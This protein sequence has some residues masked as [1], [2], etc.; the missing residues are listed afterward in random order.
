[1]KKWEDE[2]DPDRVLTPEE[3]SRRVDFKRR[4]H[5]KRII[6]KRWRD[7]RERQ[8]ASGPGDAA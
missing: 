3:R 5:M 1:V 2:D 6:L 7:Y 8:G 4:A